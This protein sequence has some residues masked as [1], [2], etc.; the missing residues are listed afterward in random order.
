MTAAL[1]EIGE[2]CAKDFTTRTTEFG[3][4]R[5]AENEPVADGLSLTFGMIRRAQVLAKGTV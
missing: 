2:A 4:S 3:E 5:C 1:K